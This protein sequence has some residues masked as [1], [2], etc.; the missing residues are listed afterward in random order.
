MFAT[1]CTPSVTRSS[2]GAP[3][4]ATSTVGTVATLT[5]A[6]LGL[7]GVDAGLVAEIAVGIAGAEPIA[8]TTAFGGAAPS[9]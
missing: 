1:R 9:A 5:S 7:G 2:R 6:G 3:S 8:S 4:M